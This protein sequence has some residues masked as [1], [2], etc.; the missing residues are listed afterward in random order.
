MNDTID[1]QRYI[2]LGLKWWWL[3]LIFAGLA[4]GTGYWYSSQQ[5]RVYQA[6]VTLLVGQSI[7]ASD[8]SAS[9]LILSERLA[10]TYADM[11]RRQPV[12]QAVA[13]RLSLVDSWSALRSRAKASCF[14][15]ERSEAACRRPSCRRSRRAC[16][17]R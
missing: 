17:T 7:Q 3:L 16:T 5:T 12:L 9:D 8:L 13:D 11:A 15:T 2:N 4:A 10:Q 14:R 1:L 6:T